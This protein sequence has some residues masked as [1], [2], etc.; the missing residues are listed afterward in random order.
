MLCQDAVT[1]V[2]YTAD[3]LH[4]AGSMRCSGVFLGELLDRLRRKMEALTEVATP[5]VELLA[6]RMT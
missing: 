6:M 1:P 3:H 2:A 4:A 5:L